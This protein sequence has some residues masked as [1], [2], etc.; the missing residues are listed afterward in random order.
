MHSLADLLS[1]FAIDDA[2]RAKAYENSSP[3]QRASIKNAIA[4]H[5]LNGE[6]ASKRSIE[7]S[8]QAKGYMVSKQINPVP[9]TLCICADNYASSARLVAALMPACMAQVPKIFVVHATTKPN[10]SLLLALELLGV[11]DVYG[12]SYSNFS[13][14]EAALS[15]CKSK[16]Y[17]GRILFLG[18]DASFDS[19][20]S[21]AKTL[22]IPIWSEPSPPRIYAQVDKAQEDLLRWAQ[23]DAVFVKKSEPC[24]EA[25]YGELNSDM[26]QESCT[27]S[28][29]WGHNM[30]A[31]YVHRQL[32][33][34]FF[35]NT[36][37][38][39]KTLMDEHDE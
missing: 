3:V 31:C 7:N 22:Q 38:R 26:K 34:D 1:P 32:N 6:G 39:A 4:F 16:A 14:L 19:L 12:I 2:L 30:Q 35:Q 37:L 28:Q 25:F 13:I 29:H 15:S 33:R 8:Y 24:V 20:Q 23:G 5:S 21:Q 10:S 9:F 17:A 27:F 11:E 36:F 18:Q